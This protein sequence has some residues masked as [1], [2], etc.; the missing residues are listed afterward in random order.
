ME[1]I[2]AIRGTSPV[3]GSIH[4]ANHASLCPPSGGR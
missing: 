4:H 3:S 1:A 2:I